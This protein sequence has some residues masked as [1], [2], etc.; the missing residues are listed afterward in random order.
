MGRYLDGELSASER[1]RFREHTSRCT[2]CQ[3]ELGLVEAVVQLLKSH[4]PGASVKAPPELWD[5]IQDR[6]ERQPMN[7]R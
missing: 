7:N 5:A 4:K 6:L 3:Q 1:N 2:R